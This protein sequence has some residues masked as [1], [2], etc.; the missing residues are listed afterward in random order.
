[1]K[2]REIFNNNITIFICSFFNDITRN[3]KFESFSK[4]I[5][6]DRFF[7]CVLMSLVLFGHAL[8]I[9]AGFIVTCTLISELLEKQNKSERIS[10]RNK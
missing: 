2:I 10:K 3:F 6:L 8:Q 1:M 9:T 7:S 5:S 4:V